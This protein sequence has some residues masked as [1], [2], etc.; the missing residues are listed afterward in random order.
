MELIQ[1]IYRLTRELPASETYGLASQAQRAAV[2]IAANIAEGNGRRTLKDYARFL[3]IATGSA[4]EVE[5]LLAVMELV[6]KKD[7]TRAQAFVTEIQKMLW[8]MTNLLETKP[9]TVPAVIP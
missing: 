2:S 4:Y 8:K 5:T 1:E 9:S 7:I 3:T 6:H